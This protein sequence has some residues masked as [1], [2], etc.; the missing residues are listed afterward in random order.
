MKR[1]IKAPKHLQNK[2]VAEQ[3][4]A[5]SAA[6]QILAMSPDEIEQWVREQKS[7]KETVVELARCISYLAKQLEKE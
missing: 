7:T 5:R 2:R 1:T 6:L 3:Q 4:A